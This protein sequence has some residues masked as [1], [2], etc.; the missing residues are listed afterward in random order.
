MPAI[1]A[2]GAATAR[3]AGMARSYKCEPLPGWKIAP[4]RSSHFFICFE[5]TEQ[6]LNTPVVFCQAKSNTSVL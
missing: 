4:C 5:F 3:F 2:G 6:I 1:S